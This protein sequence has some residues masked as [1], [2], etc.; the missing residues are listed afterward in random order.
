LKHAKRPGRPAG[1]PPSPPGG[2]YWIWGRHAVAAVLANP[3]RRIRRLVATRNAAVDLGRDA[4]VVEPRDLDRLLGDAVHQGV[5]ALVDPLPELDTA[6]AIERGGLVLVL[7]QVT[8][9]QNVGALFRTAAAF[10]AGAVIQQDRKSPPVTGALAKAAAGAVE[11]VA[12]VRVVN[13]ARALEELKEAGYQVVG[14]A[15]EARADVEAVFADRPIAVVMGAE[16]AGLRPLVAQ[17][18]DVLARIDIDP[19][20]E[21]LNVSAAASIA[22]S[23]A[24]RA[25][26]RHAAVALCRRY[27]RLMEARDLE[28][29]RTLLAPGFAMTF[30]GGLRF[31]APE[32]LAAWSAG[33]YRSIAKT[34]DHA[35]ATDAPGGMLV[36]LQ[37]RLAGEGLYGEPFSGVRF[38][39]WFRVEG[40]LIRDQRV[41]NDLDALLPGSGPP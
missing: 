19:A 40:G 14:L 23:A 28:A 2:P 17:T 31:A 35:D 26:R 36:T 33:R 10:G 16:G 8:D 24:R 4:E 41:W 13:I 1:P 18:C 22:L 32:E 15:G 37:G 3:A 20:M 7:D 38:I 5:A 6:D 12:D 29:A 27:L 11:T 39:D 21:S 34:Y 30:P 25:A 9:P